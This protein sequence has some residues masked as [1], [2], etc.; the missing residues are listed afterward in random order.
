MSE[1]D[2][3][4]ASL[5]RTPGMGI[6]QEENKPTSSMPYKGPRNEVKKSRTNDESLDINTKAQELLK[7]LNS[8]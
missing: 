6:Y 2:E 7:Q 1:M 8:S 5:K 3:L 4:L